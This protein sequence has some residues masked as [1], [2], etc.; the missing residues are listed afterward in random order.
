MD[1]RAQRIKE[2]ENI[3]RRL[4][5]VLKALVDHDCHYDAG[6]I[7]ITCNSHGD[8]ISRMYEARRAVE[9]AERYL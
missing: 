2:L 1:L 3:N 5:K 4:L 8:A 7:H 6:E 9:D